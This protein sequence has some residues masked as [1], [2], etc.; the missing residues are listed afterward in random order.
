MDPVHIDG[1]SGFIDTAGRIVTPLH[2][3]AAR[4]FSEGRAAVLVVKQWDS[5]TALVSR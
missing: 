1:K 4:D 3:D 5:S 2:F